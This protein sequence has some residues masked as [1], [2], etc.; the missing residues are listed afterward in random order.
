MSYRPNFLI[1]YT[2]QQQGYQLGCMGHAN[3]RTPH[4]DSVA[5]E[6]VLFERAYTP[7]TVCMPARNSLVTGLNVRG[8]RVT[9]N[10]CRA[11]SGVATI[12]GMLSMAGYRT[13]AA[14]KI[15]L[16]PVNLPPGY[17][18]EDVSP[19]DFPEA[20][21]M[22]RTGKIDKLPLPYYGFDE[23]DFANGHGNG[24]YGEYLTWLRQADRE[25]EKLLA[26]ERAR[27]P[28]SGAW[29][30]W[31]SALPV[32]LHVNR[33]VA[34]RTIAFLRES[35]ASTRPFLCWTS[36]PDPHFPWC[37]SHPY[38]EMYDPAE[39]TLPCDA[40]APLPERPRSV[41]S[42][43]RGLFGKMPT[44]RYRGESLREITAHAYGMV[45]HVDDE[46]GRV[47]ETLEKTGLRE[48]TVVIFTSDHGELLGK[49]GLLAKGPTNVEELIRVPLVI[50]CP[51][52]FRKGMRVESVV[53]TL[54]VPATILSL[55]GVEYPE[56]PWAQAA[57]CEG[58]PE[59]LNGVS[60]EPILV[61][62]VEAVRERTLVEYDEDYTGSTD[63]V[64]LKT[65]VT[66]RY[67]LNYYAGEGRG[68]LYDLEEDPDEIHDLWDDPGRRKIRNDLVAQ[69]AEEVI[70]T[71]AWVPR[72]VATS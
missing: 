16:E 66:R 49:R 64:R 54:D 17:G 12:P 72:R 69:L 70:T 59:A 24:V 6:G 71:E 1:V 29:S 32:E 2:D 48:N 36:F 13:Y 22:W 53:N 7:N 28:A 51:A 34:D 47:L 33:W 11:R 56:D 35:A 45:T 21:P 38:D 26:K 5:R 30:S 63:R 27:C 41:A 39:V 25:A 67:K 37:P 19:A 50:S 44:R 57:A 61:G 23:I 8:H 20:Q 42:Y 65:L 14:G 68:E 15:H 9:Q 18:V 40:D 3:L 31:K 60:L 55:A 4:I 43:W 10:G 58:L 62:A 52:R 46:V